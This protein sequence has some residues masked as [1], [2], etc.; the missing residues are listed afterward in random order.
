[1]RIKITVLFFALVTALTSCDVNE[2]Y[3]TTPSTFNSPV[4]QPT[5]VPL[6]DRLP[7]WLWEM[8]K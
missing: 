5:P 6:E 1:M 7:G 3:Y 4:A 8:V 2:V